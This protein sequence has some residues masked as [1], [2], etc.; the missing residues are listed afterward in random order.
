MKRSHYRAL[1]LSLSGAL[2]T[3]CARPTQQ[4]RKN[5]NERVACLACAADANADRDRDAGNCRCLFVA[6]SLLFDHSLYKVAA[7]APWRLGTV[8]RNT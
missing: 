1:P 2:T 8:G 6:I 7:W 5:V 4:H 3:H